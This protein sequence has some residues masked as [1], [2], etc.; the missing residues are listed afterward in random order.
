MDYI[1]LRCKILPESNQELSDI[2]I[3][4]LNEV[5]FESYDE[6]DHGVNAYILEKFFDINKVKQ[7]QI[8]N[9]PNINIQYD[10]EVIKSQNW[11]EVW[12]KGCD[13]IIL[14][15]QCRIRSPF[16]DGTP[17]LK[18]E[19]IIEPKMSFGTGHHETT[20]LMLKIL[21]ETD[22]NNK[23][24]LDMGCGTGV[25]A[26]LSSLKGAKEV[27]AIDIDQW[28]Y[29]NTLENIEK[30]NCK[31]INVLKG[32]ASILTKQ[33]FEIII[34]NINRNIL[35]DDIKHYSKVLTPEGILI[36]SGIYDKDLDMIRNETFDN[37]LE[38][39]SYY[40]KNSWI[41]ARFEKKLFDL[42]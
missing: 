23:T 10:W 32:N 30:N 1:E 41:A 17:K 12:E 39:I 11:N 29:T 26:I 21:L 20:Y 35:M 25:L 33:K 37:N 42:K 2:L 13:A 3:A 19:I 31:N 8:N 22:L 38:F 18:Y 7:L 6:T 28:A 40:E 24:V 4:E 34:A 5:G 14:E 36:L 16:H 15:G 27:T 9:I